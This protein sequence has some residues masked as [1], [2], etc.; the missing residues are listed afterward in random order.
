MISLLRSLRAG[1]IDI[2]SANHTCYCDPPLSAITRLSV[3]VCVENSSL[4]ACVI[5]IPINAPG[6][7][8]SVIYFPINAPGMGRFQLPNLGVLGYG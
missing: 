4:A 8:G 3:A 7:V 5:V 6:S 1:A 2:L